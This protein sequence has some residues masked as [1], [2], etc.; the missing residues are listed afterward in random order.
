MKPKIKFIRHPQNK[1]YPKKFLL[2]KNGKIYDN[3]KNYY[4]IHKIP[5]FGYYQRWEND[6]CVWLNKLKYWEYILL[7]IYFFIHKKCKKY[8]L[9][10]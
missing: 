5:G 2:I 8:K 1:K 6:Y 3:N 7:K 10:F 4:G 9:I